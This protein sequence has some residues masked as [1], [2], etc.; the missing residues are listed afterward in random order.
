VDLSI[1]AP[2]RESEIV[3]A[4]DAASAHR[5]DGELAAIEEALLA[6]THLHLAGWQVLGLVRRHDEPVG[7][8]GWVPIDGGR[9][10]SLVQLGPGQ[11]SAALVDPTLCWLAHSGDRLRESHD[12]TSLESLFTIWE[13]DLA[14]GCARALRQHQWDVRVAG[15]AWT[16]RWEPMVRSTVR[17]VDW[18]DAALPHRCLRRRT[19]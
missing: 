8:I 14:T 9:W 15:P 10:S 1:T 12:A 5:L 7:W 19:A 6:V 3:R 18:T 2:A 13:D 4:F 17:A 16:T 11:D